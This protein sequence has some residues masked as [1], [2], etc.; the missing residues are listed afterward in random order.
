MELSK[1]DLLAL[2][3]LSE[4]PLGARTAWGTHHLSLAKPFAHGWVDVTVPAMMEA[5][6]WSW[7]WTVEDPAGPEPGADIFSFPLT[8]DAVLE[9]QIVMRARASVLSLSQVLNQHAVYFG[10]GAQG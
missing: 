1:E 3:W 7:V 5:V 4:R 9:M 10:T 2:A 8:H 6:G